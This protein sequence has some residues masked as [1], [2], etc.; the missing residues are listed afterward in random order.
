MRRFISNASEVF[1]VIQS[2]SCLHLRRAVWHAIAE[3]RMCLNTFRNNRLLVSSSPFRSK[4]SNLLL[5]PAVGH[6][7]ETTN[8]WSGRYSRNLKLNTKKRFPRHAIPSTCQSPPLPGSVFGLGLNWSRWLFVA[9]E[10]QLSSPNAHTQRKP[11]PSYVVNNVCCACLAAS[12]SCAVL[13]LYS[14]KIRSSV[15]FRQAQ[16]AR[17]SM[18][19]TRQLYTTTDIQAASMAKL[20]TSSS[21]STE[22]SMPLSCCPMTQDEMDC[23][24]PTVTASPPGLASP[25]S[26]SS[27]SLPGSPYTRNNSLASIPIIWDGSTNATEPDSS[28]DI[29]GLGLAREA[30][31]SKF[32]DQSSSQNSKHCSIDSSRS[33]FALSAYMTC[34]ETHSNRSRSSAEEADRS[35]KHGIQRAKGFMRSRASTLDKISDEAPFTI[36]TRPNSRQTPAQ[37]AL[38]APNYSVAIPDRHSYNISD[39]SHSSHSSHSALSRETT[40]ESSTSTSSRQAMLQYGAFLP[41][42]PSTTTA[43]YA[44]L[45][46]TDESLHSSEIPFSTSITLLFDQEGWRESEVTFRMVRRDADTGDLEYCAEPPVELPFNASRMQAAPVLRR[47]LVGEKDNL[48]RQASLSIKQNGEWN[49]CG[50]EGK[51]RW[52]FTYKVEDRR[53]A[54]G[55]PKPGEKV[56]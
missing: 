4:F 16:N 32:P 22:L 39:S 30:E 47:I 8:V 3:S 24:S 51:G 19:D 1:H 54:S 17:N 5:K 9:F 50:R 13:F 26:A 43:S 44:E 29:L 2:E 52:I 23:L 33:Q 20:T 37:A 42:M 48:T 56:R 36:A 34:P 55:R 15:L 18:A 14:Q 53:K 27:L 11:L 49:V 12:F 46:D 31:S 35:D 41:H 21:V 10:H 45:S 25:G 7:N 38:F 28:A 6:S 40:V